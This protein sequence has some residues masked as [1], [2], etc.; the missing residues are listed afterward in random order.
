MNVNIATEPLAFPVFQNIGV[1]GPLDPFRPQIGSC[2]ISFYISIGSQKG[3]YRIP[4]FLARSC[5]IFMYSIEELLDLANFQP[6][7]LDVNDFQPEDSTT[8]HVRISS[9]KMFEPLLGSHRKHGNCRNKYDLGSE[10]VQRLIF[11]DNLKNG[12]GQQAP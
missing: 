9:Q 7:V 11:T 4:Y 10:G 1:N 3:L 6:E 5:S 2:P 8:S 12:T